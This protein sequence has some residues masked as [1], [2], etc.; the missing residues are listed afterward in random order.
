M[1]AIEPELAET[2]LFIGTLDVQ[3]LKSKNKT[4][5]VSVHEVNRI[6]VREEEWNVELASGETKIKFKIDT[7][8]KCNVI[9][10]NI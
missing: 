10:L 8:A 7:G 9:S 6:S 2:D 5:E 1:H 3:E 4:N